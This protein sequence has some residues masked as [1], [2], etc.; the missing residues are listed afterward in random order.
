M[1]GEVAAHCRRHR[2][3]I[4]VD[5]DVLLQHRQPIP[6]DLEDAAAEGCAVEVHS[7]LELLMGGTGSTDDPNVLPTVVNV[8]DRPPPPVGYRPEG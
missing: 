5:Q 3:L 1:V 7:E 8:P 6:L 4:T 2:F